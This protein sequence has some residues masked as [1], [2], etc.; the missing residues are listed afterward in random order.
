[1]GAHESAPV[2]LRWLAA[3]FIIVNLYYVARQYYTIIGLKIHFTVYL[4]VLALLLWLTMA[5]SFLW[6]AGVEDFDAGSPF[7]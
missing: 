2:L 4:N 7:H 5:R 6:Q 1:M 3:A